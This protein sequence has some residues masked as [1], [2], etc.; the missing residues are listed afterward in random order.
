LVGKIYIRKVTKNVTWQV[1]II[2]ETLTHFYIK[3]LN[4]NTI[5][6]RAFNVSKDWFL[7]NYT[8]CV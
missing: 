1:Q 7:K 3:V 8:E 6:R 2:D 4:P 5:I